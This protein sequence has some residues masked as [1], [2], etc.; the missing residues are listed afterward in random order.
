MTTHSVWTDEE[1]QLIRDNYN[2]DIRVIDTCREIQTLLPEKSI[3]QIRYQVVKDG[4]LE[5][6]L[7]LLYQILALLINL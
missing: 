5:I 7:T 3:R 1:I 4:L 2:P 6:T